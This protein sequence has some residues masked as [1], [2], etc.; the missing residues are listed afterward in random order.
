[1]KRAAKL[2]ACPGCK[3]PFNDYFRVDGTGPRICY[4]CRCSGFTWTDEGERYDARYTPWRRVAKVSD[5]RSDS[6][7][8]GASG[9]FLTTST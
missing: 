1:V 3:R 4:P 2:K 6:E 5:T 8:G 7:K 9:V